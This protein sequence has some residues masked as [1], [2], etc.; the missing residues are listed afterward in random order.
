MRKRFL[1]FKL[2][3]MRRKT[4]SDVFKDPKKLLAGKVT[5]EAFEEILKA[6]KLVI[7]FLLDGATI[8]TPVRIK[9]IIKKLK[10]LVEYVLLCCT[11]SDITKTFTS[12]NDDQVSTEGRNIMWCVTRFFDAI[13]TM[14]KDKSPL[15]RMEYT[16]RYKSY[17]IRTDTSN[18]LV[19]VFLLVKK[20][21]YSTGSE[22]NQATCG[23]LANIFALFSKA[24]YDIELKMRKEVIDDIMLPIQ[25]FSE[26][27]GDLPVGMKTPPQLTRKG[28]KRR[29]MFKSLSPMPIKRRLCTLYKKDTRRVDE[30]VL[31]EGSEAE[32]SPCLFSPMPLQEELEA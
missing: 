20:R 13:I 18:E 9:W 8:A 17:Q 11:A 10:L 14:A 12:L 22:H 21:T 6:Q 30:A 24:V 28:R 16:L 5:L 23:L 31:E 1:L 15:V 7:S 4:I 19:S 26:A 25:W 2:P 29:C 3:F 32:E 27:T